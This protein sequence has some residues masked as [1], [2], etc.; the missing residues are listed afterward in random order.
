MISQKPISIIFLVL[1][2]FSSNCFSQDIKNNKTFSKAQI[3]KDIDY[4]IEKYEEIHPM[5]YLYTDSIAILQFKKKITDNLT[6]EVSIFEARQA[7][8][9]IASK[10]GLGH[11]D[12]SPNVLL[13]REEERAKFPFWVKLK[14]DEIIIT[15]NVSN[16]STIEN[17][18]K[19]TSINGIPSRDIVNTMMNSVSGEVPQFKEAFLSGSFSNYLHFFFGFKGP[20]YQLEIKNKNEQISTHTLHRVSLSTVANIN[21]QSWFE[22]E[23]L[24]NETALIHIKGF[25]DKKAFR[26]FLKDAF[27]QLASKKTKTLV[28]DIRGNYGGNTDRIIQLASYLTSDPI[29]IFDDGV[30]KTSKASKKYWHKKYIKWYMYPLYP[31]LYIIPGAGPKFTKKSGSI[32]KSG[33]D[34]VKPKKVKN[35]YIGEIYVLVDEGTFSTASV[36]ASVLQCAG[37]A[38]IV[39]RSTGEPVFGDGN[40]VEVNLPNTQITHDI[41]TT[42][43]TNACHKNA[44]DNKMLIPDIYTGEKDELKFLLEK[45]KE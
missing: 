37:I 12:I 32:T 19:I 18:S 21:K 29:T 39:G 10:Y 4:L 44:D 9:A 15:K 13:K 5:P 36:F 3:I 20:D 14:N 25:V 6:N 34:K 24:E 42:L 33:I 22:L 8:G 17:L 35:K 28:L 7:T 26:R 1:Y 40:S 45:I 41:G 23:F 11:S 16:D 31:V 43:W 27:Q 30:E 2:I 38:K